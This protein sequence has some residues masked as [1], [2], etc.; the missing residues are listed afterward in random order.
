MTL[1]E[2]A[3]VFGASG[4][5]G[6]EIANQMSALGVD[7]TRATRAPVSDRNWVSTSDPRWHQKLIGMPFSRIIF[8]QG[9]NSSGGILQVTGDSIRE[10]MDANVISTVDWVKRLNESSLM[11]NPA[12]ICIIG[13]VWANIARQDKLAYT[14]AKS[15]VS[16]L[17][18]SLCA[19]LSVQGITVNALLPG[20]VDSPMTR[21]FLDE[22][23]L[24]KL[25][26][27]TPS[28]SLV[29]SKEVATI[30]MWLTSPDSH[31]ISGQSIV[32]DN[33]WSAIRYV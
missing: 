18:R 16:G 25:E 6:C 29:L 13:S 10:A 3:I 4:T 28:G 22:G 32:V 5:L 20:V 7:V 15:A 9:H 30:A 33:G 8:A 14:I 27:Q 24:L 19:D 23:S 31:G 17:V 11:M 1:P 12:R 21:K 26:E 2:R